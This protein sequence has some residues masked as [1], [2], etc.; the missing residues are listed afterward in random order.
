M[1]IYND[2]FS[3]A[4]FI[5]SCNISVDTSSNTSRKSANG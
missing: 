5:G 1:Y 3:I 2:G 4:M